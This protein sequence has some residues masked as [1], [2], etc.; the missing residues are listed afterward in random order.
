[1]SKSLVMLL[2]EISRGNDV[3]GTYHRNFNDGPNGLRFA[4]LVACPI[5]G[6]EYSTT[7]PAVSELFF[8]CV[9][10]TC[11]AVTGLGGPDNGEY[12]YESCGHWHTIKT[13][14]KW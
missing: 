1:M 13:K 7:D 3:M 12:G 11:E 4:K 5:S 9:E 2:Q 14:V 6:T 10:Y 8:E